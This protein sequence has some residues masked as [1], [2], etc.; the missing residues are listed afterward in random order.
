MRV[1]GRTQLIAISLGAHAALGVALGSVPPR[2]R[3]EVVSITV[4][5]VKKPKP[6]PHVDPLPEPDPPAQVARPL[7]AKSAPPVPKATPI[8]PAT[9][10]Q[11]SSLESLPDFG[12]S[13]SGG[14]PGGV[15]VPAGGRSGPIA[16]S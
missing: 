2:R 8:A 6:P 7:R 3:R 12:L 13:L 5:D 9:N 15:A 4:S 1:W 10:A 11:A 16:S 14:A